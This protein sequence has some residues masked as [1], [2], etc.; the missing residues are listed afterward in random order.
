MNF[1]ISVKIISIVNALGNP[2]PEIIKKYF[3]EVLDTNIEYLDDDSIKALIER[4]GQFLNDLLA[5]EADSYSQFL[6]DMRAERNKCYPA[7]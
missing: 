6:N 3:K 7:D 5:D 2:N 4:H 1:D